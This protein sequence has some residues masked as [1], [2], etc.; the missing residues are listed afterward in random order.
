VAACLLDLT[1]LSS[2][3]KF[4]GSVASDIFIQQI[5]TERSLHTGAFHDLEKNLRI[6]IAGSD[7]AAITELVH[8]SDALAQQN[9]AKTNVTRILWKAIIEAPP[10]LADLILSS[11]RAAFDFAFIDDI[12]GRTCLHGAAMAG[13]LRLVEICLEKGVQTDKVDVYG[14]SALHYACMNGHENVCRRLMK[15]KLPLNILDMDNYSPLIYATLNG[16]VGCVRALLDEGE[17]SVQSLTPIGDLV[18]LSL[19]SQSGHVDIVLLLLQHGAKSVPNSNGEYPLHLAAREG[20][21]DVCK[22]LVH[23]EGWDTPDKY[24]EWTPLFHAAR[25]GHDDCIKVLLEARCRVSTLDEF[26][27]S[28]VHYAA[29][30][31]HHC[32]VRRLLEAAANI[33]ADNDDAK[34]VD[35]SPMSIMEK[36]P[37]M[38]IDH[39]PSLLLPP[40]IMPHRVYGH[41]YL[42]R[43]YLVQVSIGHPSVRYREPS[44][45]RSAVRLHHRLINPSS[46][47]EH[48]LATT[49]LKLVMTTS[50]DVNSAPYSIS[51]PQR[52][53]E[54]FFMF[55][56]SSLDKLSLEFSVYPNF[57]T[58]TIGR[59]VALPS[60]FT[61]IQN[62]QPFV[63]P[64]LDN[65]LHV[66]GEV[67]CPASQTYSH[68][69]IN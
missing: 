12:N 59:A 60:L 8:Y 15:A 39:I 43:S 36:P 11:M 55:Q 1:D 40:P 50:P 24:H 10:D 67:I 62:G 21:V 46:R 7:R 48:L 2:G 28:A 22:L 38:D 5:M 3:L 41:N 30:Y 68:K 44:E 63:L 17:I 42:G 49:P 69:S 57:G 27:H 13:V 37:V 16:S 61:G 58:K 6:A 66:I 26:D 31:G 20:H 64:I 23:Q 56:V 45:R 47:D 34:L 54:G 19:A 25:Y 53:E 18:P 14:R 52:D 4:E 51:L 35:S 32:C 9:G 29:W 33:P 65:R